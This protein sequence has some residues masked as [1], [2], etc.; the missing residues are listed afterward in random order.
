MGRINSHD[1]PIVVLRT[2]ITQ[3][4][5]EITGQYGQCKDIIMTGSK[6]PQDA[7]IPHHAKVCTAIS[8]SIPRDI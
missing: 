8:K 6:H 2:M 4:E 5:S 1:T 7:T 3:K